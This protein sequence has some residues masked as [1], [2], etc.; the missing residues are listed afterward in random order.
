MNQE[1]VVQALQDTL[2]GLE[3][4]KNTVTNAA[5][6]EGM[7]AAYK[8]FGERHGLLTYINE[9]QAQSRAALAM[10]STPTK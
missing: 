1:F 5:T 8:R 4:W 10:L 2:T 3:D 7:R 9:L 6:G